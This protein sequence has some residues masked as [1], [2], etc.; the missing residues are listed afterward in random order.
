MKNVLVTGGAGYIGSHTVKELR[1]AGFRPIVFDNLSTGHRD[2]VGETELI[3]GDLRDPAAIGRVCRNGDFSAILHFASLS[4]VGESYVHPRKYYF[5]NLQNA[6]NLLEAALDTGIRR[7]IFSSSAAVYG[8]PQETP[9]REDHPL[10]P[11]NPYGWTKA[12]IERILED[13]D[14]GYG[15]RFV[16]LRYFNAAGADPEGELGERHDPE[17]HLIPNTLKAVLGQGTGL[18]LFGTDFPTPD[19][20]AV[21]DYIHVT[22]LAAAHVLALQYLQDGGTSEIIN[23]GTNRGYSVREVI[24]AAEK[25]TGRRVPREEKPRRKG[26]PPILLAS[27]EKAERVL[28][29]KSRYSDLGKILETAWAWHRKRG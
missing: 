24:A 23:L 28:G 29:W 16:S 8:I 7:F 25:I 20:T 14:R 18:S 22:D 2:A 9:I 4:Q 5:Q 3:E 19:G 11:I 12:M 6:L 21:R 1:R 17:T 13:Y 26:D 10:A 15:L 27:N